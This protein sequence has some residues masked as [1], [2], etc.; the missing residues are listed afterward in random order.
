M[1]EL[2]E[3]RL[4]GGGQGVSLFGKEK[5]GLWGGGGGWARLY[6]ARNCRPSL[7]AR[8]CTRT[9]Y[10][11]LRDLVPMVCRVCCCCRCCCCFRVWSRV[12]TRRRQCGQHTGPQ[13][14]HM[15]DRGTEHVLVGLCPVDVHVRGAHDSWAGKVLGKSAHPL[16]GAPLPTLS[17]TCCRL[18]LHSM[19]YISRSMWALRGK[20]GELR[21]C[22]VSLSCARRH[23]QCLE[24][25]PVPVWLR[26][27]LHACLCMLTG[28]GHRP[29]QQG[30]SPGPGAAVWSRGVPVRVTIGGHAQRSHVD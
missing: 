17:S 3:N 28:C 27:H 7:V 6:M 20:G 2:G 14:G 16:P 11:S 25:W 8:L 29:Q 19:P 4:R 22:P 10:G 1:G 24:C 26:A 23:Y 9:R 15:A 30:F 5:W 12:P 18:L 13:A 21:S